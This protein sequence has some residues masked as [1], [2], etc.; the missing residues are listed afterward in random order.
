M[1]NY[2]WIV[3]VVALIVVPASYR[4]ALAEEAKGEVKCTQSMDITDPK[5]GSTAD[6]G[7]PVRFSDLGC[8]FVFRKTA[9]ATEQM[10]FDNSASAKDF[11]TGEPV[12]MDGASFVIDEKLATPLGYGLAAF[13]DKASAERYVSESGRGK[14]YTYSELNDMKLTR[15]AQ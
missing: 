6:V 11:Y 2:I 7:V 13:K 12:K 4:V 10:H 5:F 8:A 14:I 15:Q 3:L 1:K 9:C